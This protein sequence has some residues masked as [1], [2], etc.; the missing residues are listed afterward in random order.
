MNVEYEYNYTNINKLHSP[1]V[2]RKIMKYLCDRNLLDLLRYNN[3][4]QNLV[5]LT[6]NSYIAYSRLFSSIKIELYIDRSKIKYGKFINII[7]ENDK[8]YIHIYFNKKFNK[9]INRTY[10]KSNDKIKVIDIIIEHPITSLK[11]LFNDCIIIQ[12]INFITFNRNNITNMSHMF[13]NCYSLCEINLNNFNTENVLDMSYMFNKCSSL[14][15]LNLKSFN[16]SNVIDMSFMFYRCDSLQILYCNNFIT[17]NVINIDHIF[18]YC[19]YLENIDIDIF[20]MNTKLI[21]KYIFT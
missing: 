17:L 10:I 7:E 18:G 19:L 16:T 20:K 15:F 6:N 5:N 13:S 14:E 2:F 9:K 8:K 12:K 21:S 1:F 11:D 4:F 3:R